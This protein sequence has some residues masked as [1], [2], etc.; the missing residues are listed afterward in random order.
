MSLSLTIGRF[1]NAH[2]RLVARHPWLR[3][4]PSLIAAIGLVS[5]VD[6]HQSR[7]DDEMRSWGETAEVWVAAA[8]LAPGDPMRAVL[9]DVP[10]AL[11]PETA[12]DT[13]LEPASHRVRQH[14][15]GGE[16]MTDA[17]VVGGDGPIALVPQGWRAVPVR[18][19]PAS[20]AAVGD[21]VDLAAEGLVLVEGGIVIDRFDDVTLVAVPLEQA[22]L[23]AF[24]DA[25]GVTLLRSPLAGAPQ[26]GV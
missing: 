1:T 20:G 21:R 18:E 6:A 25:S 4:F 17:D 7:L 13:G 16:L 19:R 12:L 14:V 2:R 9:R 8:D 10:R 15:G 3:W 22:A 24:A 23:V 5:A 26:P 11:V